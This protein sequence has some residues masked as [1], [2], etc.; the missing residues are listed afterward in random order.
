MI[1]FLDLDAMVNGAPVKGVSYES[2]DIGELCDVPM[3][4]AAS[5]RIA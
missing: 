1:I 3:R 2:R 5:L 4:Q